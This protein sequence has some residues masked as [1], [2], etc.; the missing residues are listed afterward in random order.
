MSPKRQ[1]LNQIRTEGETAFILL[2]RRDGQIIEAIVDAAD[3]QRIIAIGLRWTASWST[4][5]VFRVLSH[6]TVNGKKKRIVLARILTDAPSGLDVDHINRNPLDNRMSNLRIVTKFGNMQNHP[7]NRNKNG[8]KGVLYGPNRR[9]KRKYQGRVWVD[10]KVHSLGL[11]ATAS[12]AG[13]AVEAA[14]AERR[15]YSPLDLRDHLSPMED[16]PCA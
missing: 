14:I 11:F 16:Q 13:A 9:G 12:E 1:T 3:I 2:P 10:G 7:Q 15:G 6:R 4:G 5:R 8:F